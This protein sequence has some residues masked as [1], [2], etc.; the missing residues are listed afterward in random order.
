MTSKSFTSDDGKSKMWAIGYLC[1]ESWSRRECD[2]SKRAKMLPAK[3]EI[4]TRVAGVSLNVKAAKWLLKHLSLAI[5][6]AE[7]E[8]GKR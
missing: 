5:E 7:A 6:H 2:V 8:E 4:C 3:I 1:L